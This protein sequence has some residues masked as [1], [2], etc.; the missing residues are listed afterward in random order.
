MANEFFKRLKSVAMQPSVMEWQKPQQVIGT[1]EV[2]KAVEVLKKYKDG[3]TNLEKTIVENEK[4]Y[5]LRHWDVFKG[6]TNNGKRKPG[7]E[8]PEPASAWLFNSLSNKHAD[9]MDNYPEP[10]V[11]P[12]EEG[13]KKDAEMLS[14]I[15]PAILER[16]DFESTYSNAWWYKLKHGVV[17]YGVFWNNTLENGLGDIDSISSGN[18]V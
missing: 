1:K 8:R 17:P 10:N 9:A 14:S 18:P 15:I 5:R 7:D 2:A 4:W 3:K 11:L 13:D 12:R 6:T 16:N